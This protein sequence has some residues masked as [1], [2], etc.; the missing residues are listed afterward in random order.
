MK[1]AITL[2]FLL[3]VLQV[4]TGSF[5][6]F[7]RSHH[8]IS[9]LEKRAATA[10][11][12]VRKS[13]SILTVPQGTSG[14]IDSSATCGILDSGALINP[15]QTSGPNGQENWMNCGLNGAGWSPPNI[16]IPQIVTVE[17]STALQNPQSPFLACSSYLS[18]FNKYGSLYEIP[19]ILLASFAMQESACNPNAVGEG[20]EQGLMQISMDKCGQ[21]SEQAC[22]DPDYN[23]GTAAHY[24]MQTLQQIDNNVFAAVG[25]YNGWDVGLTVAKATAARNSSCCRCQNNLDYL[26]Q[27]FNGWCQNVDPRVLNMGIYFNLEVCNDNS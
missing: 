2:W 10:K 6:F 16:T 17:L 4:A 21:L 13:Q 1:G 7:W 9:T 12:I 22:R 11:C 18:I 14:T 5:N 23:I 15:T 27:F 26:Q 8:R 25:M 3:Q 24:F 19:P 20:G